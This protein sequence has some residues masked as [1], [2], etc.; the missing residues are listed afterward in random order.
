MYI[1]SGC[2]I[3]YMCMYAFVFH[4]RQNICGMLYPN[5]AHM[6]AEVRNFQF[7]LACCER[8]WKYFNLLAKCACI[9]SFRSFSACVPGGW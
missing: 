6:M 7:N 3:R 8:K 1:P 2:C 4:E 9:V 5:N